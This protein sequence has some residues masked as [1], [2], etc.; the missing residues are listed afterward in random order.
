MPGSKCLFATVLIT[1]LLACTGS[2]QNPP[3]AGDPYVQRGKST[4][5]DGKYEWRVYATDEIRYQLI[6]LQTGKELAAVN[7]YYPDPNSSNLHY[8]KAY[9]VFWNEDGTVVALDELNRRRA[10]NLYFFIL[11]GGMVSEI[12]PEK[13][14]PLPADADEGRLVVDPGWVSSTTIRVRQAVKTRKGEFAS[15]YFTIDFANP[16]IPKAE[17]AG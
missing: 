10:G 14:I 15:R 9:G 8:A 12:R 5:P 6:N 13:L 3:L 2:A 17:P 4:S 11:R 7:A 1:W 16:D